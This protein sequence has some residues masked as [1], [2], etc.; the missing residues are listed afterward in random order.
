KEAYSHVPVIFGGIQ[1]SSRRSARCDY[2]PAKVP[3]SILMDAT[4]D[5]LLY[6]NAQPA[7]VDIAQRL[8]QGELVTAITD[9]RGTAFVRRD[10]PEGW[11]EI[12]STR[13]DRPG[14]IDK[15]INPYENN[16]NTAA[17]T[18]EQKKSAQEDPQEAK[19]VKLLANPRLTRAKTVLHLPAFV[20]V[21]SAPVVYGH[22]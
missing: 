14:K 19:V 15:I 12:D 10:T 1:A 8:A 6:G 4:A 16:Q 22:R 3:R 18:I 20:K 11:F 17:C 9:V 2:W 5:I 7:V 21:G 13:I